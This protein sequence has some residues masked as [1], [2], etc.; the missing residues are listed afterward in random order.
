MFHARRFGARVPGSYMMGRR[1]EPRREHAVP[2][3]KP[4]SG[5]SKTRSL[6]TVPD[7][8][9]IDL[10]RAAVFSVTLAFALTAGW[11]AYQ[12]FLRGPA[13][14]L[15]HEA[16]ASPNTAIRV[17]FC[18]AQ[19]QDYVSGLA[20]E[21]LRVIPAMPRLNS[22][23][24]RARRMDW[25]HHLPLEFAFLFSQDIPGRLDTL[26]YIRED[27]EGP[28]F[29]EVIN[30]SEFFYVTRPIT[31]DSSRVRRVEGNALLAQGGIPIRD[32]DADAAERFWPAFTPPVPL[33]LSGTHFFEV[34]ADNRSGAL[35]ELHTAVLSAH[36]NMHVLAF[37][38]LIDAWAGVEELRLTADLAGDNLIEFDATVATARGATAASLEQPLQDALAAFAD[39]LRVEPGL[40]LEWNLSPTPGEMQIE[41]TL[42]GFDPLL[43]RALSPEF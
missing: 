29:P 39:A 41:A 25:L 1:C 8:F 4:K 37:D 3:K 2:D 19:V 43:R 22:L 9:R 23:A 27:S 12:H 31:W 21:V 7:F 38:A 32:G 16:A 14:N 26:L 20:P 35:Y 15:G 30:D 40:T 34:S 13:A 36:P 17:V 42:S 5:R 6:G 11:F 18:G 24:P 28:N 10:R 33:P